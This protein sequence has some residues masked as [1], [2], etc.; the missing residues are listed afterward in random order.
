MSSKAQRRSQKVSIEDNERVWNVKTIAALAGI[1]VLICVLFFAAT[2]IKQSRVDSIPREFEGRIVDKW[3]G[4]NESERG[5]SPYY[6]VSVEVEGQQ[7]ISVPVNS[8][9]YQ[10]AQVGMILKRTDKGLEVV[11]A[12]EVR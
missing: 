1:L 2:A 10:Q 5:S 6:R 3:A 11:R 9:I 12:R 8:E 7:R 4:Y